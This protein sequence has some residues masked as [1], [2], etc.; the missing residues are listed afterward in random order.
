[1]GKRKSA[2]FRK[3]TQVTLGW[4]LMLNIHGENEKREPVQSRK[5]TISSFCCV[6]RSFHLLGVWYSFF[7]HCGEPFFSSLSLFIVYTFVSF[8]KFGRRHTFLH[9]LHTLHDCSIQNDNRYHLFI[10]Y[11]NTKIVDVV[12]YTVAI[13]SNINGFVSFV[14]NRNVQWKTRLSQQP[15]LFQCCMHETFHTQHTHTNTPSE[16]SSDQIVFMHV[17]SIHQNWKTTHQNTSADS[18]TDGKTSE[19]NRRDKCKRT[20]VMREQFLLIVAGYIQR[21]SQVTARPTLSTREPN[22]KKIW[23]LH[24]L[25]YI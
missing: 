9:C 3:A 12:E 18:R 25:L 10:I 11:K 17:V 6:H 21:N 23:M 20:N 7:F 5:K 2:F 13:S 19:S 14:C 1:M 24:S 22:R 16:R 8:S 15:F 4:N